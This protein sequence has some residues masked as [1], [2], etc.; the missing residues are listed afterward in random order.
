MPESESGLGAG[1]EAGCAFCQAVSVSQVSTLSDTMEINNN[2]I[3][4]RLFPPLL[5]G[6]TPTPLLISF[7]SSLSPKTPT[8]GL[9]PCKKIE[10]SDAEPA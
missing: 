9:F 5:T 10:S 2:L 4:P 3:N 7:S 6:L 1:D 8:S